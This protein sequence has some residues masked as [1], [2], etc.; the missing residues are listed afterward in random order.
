VKNG[1][2]DTKNVPDGVPDGVPNDL[3]IVVIDDHQLVSETLRSTLSAQDGLIVVGAAENGRDGIELVVSLTPDVALID[4]RLPDLTGA[5]V[6]KEIVS[7]SPSTRCVILT[8]SGQDRA[9]LESLEAGALGF[10]TKHQKFSDVV[11]AIRAAA[12]GEASIP[13]AM[14]GKVLPQI[15][16]SS[17]QTRLTE[18][19]RDVLQLLAAGRGNSDIAG[20]LFISINTVR[21]HVANILVK[22]NAKTRTEAAAIAAREGLLTTGDF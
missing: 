7:R 10:V 21:N 6:V 9:L 8:G 14:L 4:Y 1:Y 2:A 18:R 19:E 13:P 12:V 17:G 15:R 16:N 5:E 20:D 22:L 3:R 11:A